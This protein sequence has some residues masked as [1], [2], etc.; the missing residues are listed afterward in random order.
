MAYKV[1]ERFAKLLALVAGALLVIRT[2]LAFA[3]NIPL[4]GNG[5]TMPPPVIVE[6]T[7]AIKAGFAHNP[8]QESA[9]VGHVIFREEV[10]KGF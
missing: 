1:S 5:R 2:T 6:F 8:F 3:G 4:A 9:T 7:L 10:L